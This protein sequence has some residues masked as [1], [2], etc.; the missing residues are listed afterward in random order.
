MKQIEKYPQESSQ[1]EN[2]NYRM[3]SIDIAS[4]LSDGHIQALP[5]HTKI[6]PQAS[7]HPKKLKA[8]T[9]GV[10]RKTVFYFLIKNLQRLVLPLSYEKRISFHPPKT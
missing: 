9:Y 4:R 2:A 1:S 6:Q 7:K 5:R 3:K 8:A 10:P